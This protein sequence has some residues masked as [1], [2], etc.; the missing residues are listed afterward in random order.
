MSRK[1]KFEE[2]RRLSARALELA[3]GAKPKVKLEEGKV[4]LGK[5][6]VEIAKKELKE[7]LLELEIYRK[8]S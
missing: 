7:N 4:Y 8:K 1:N 5:D 3:Q 2:T 6:Y